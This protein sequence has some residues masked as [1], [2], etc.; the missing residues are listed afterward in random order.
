M[1]RMTNDLK[2]TFSRRNLRRLFLDTW[3]LQIS[4][5][6]IYWSSIGHM[7]IIL[8]I[9][10]LVCKARIHCIC[11][12]VCSFSQQSK[13]LQQ[14]KNSIQSSH[15]WSCS[16]ALDWVSCEGLIFKSFKTICNLFHSSSEPTRSIWHRML[17]T[18]H[19]RHY[20]TWIKIRK[21]GLIIASPPTHSAQ[22]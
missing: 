3:W 6:S 12:Q 14:H 2:L 17:I 19:R 9:V 5:C 10:I 4:F 8:L 1:Q 18:F 22:L 11:G 7:I 21:R 13:K 20:E 16:Y 15:L